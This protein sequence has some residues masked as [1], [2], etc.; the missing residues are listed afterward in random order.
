MI[1]PAAVADEGGDEVLLEGEAL[2]R[3]PGTWAM[4]G[5]ESRARRAIVRALTSHFVME[6]RS[7]TY[8]QTLLQP[9]KMVDARV[10]RV[11]RPRSPA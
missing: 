6:G 2:A 11:P 5:L 1:Q 3:G 4:D 9:K 10:A 8:M 7:R